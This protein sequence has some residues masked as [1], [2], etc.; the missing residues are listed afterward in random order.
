VALG[1]FYVDI[2]SYEGASTGVIPRRGALPKVGG[3]Y[4]IPYRCLV[5]QKVENLLAAGR[6]VSATHEGQASLR[7]IGTV[8]ALGQAAGTAS[9]LSLREGVSP[10]AL[11][12]RLLQRELMRQGAYLGE[13]FASAEPPLPDSG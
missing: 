3:A 11:D 7:V 9:A 10:R 1:G 8:M 13:R 6:C 2:H 5:P 4:D 12:R